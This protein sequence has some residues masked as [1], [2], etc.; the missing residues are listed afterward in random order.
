[1][2]VLL[3]SE[4]LVAPRNELVIINLNAAYCEND[5]R[6]RRSMKKPIT[7]CAKIDDVKDK[8]RENPSG[9]L[10]SSFDMLFAGFPAS[11]SQM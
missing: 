8:D 6:H 3:V 7:K 2:T 5:S 10:I 4:V 1:M 11:L 9:L